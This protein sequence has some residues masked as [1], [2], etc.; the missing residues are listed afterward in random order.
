M[1]EILETLKRAI[2]ASAK[3]R[4]TL[5]RETDVAESALSR[6]MSGERGLSI[7]AAERLAK[8][9]DLQIVIKPAKRKAGKTKDR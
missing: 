7:D 8:A 9:L 6:L 4:Y 3:S 5:A 2:E 1:S